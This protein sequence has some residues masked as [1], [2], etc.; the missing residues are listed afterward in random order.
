LCG[1]AK[2][3]A[4]QR[5]VHLLFGKRHFFDPIERVSFRLARFTRA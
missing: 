4:T 1:K 2:L 5:D 3:R